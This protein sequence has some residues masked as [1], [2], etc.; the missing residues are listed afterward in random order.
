[1]FIPT[2]NL[3]SQTTSEK[4]AKFRKLM[5]EN[6]ITKEGYYYIKDGNIIIEIVDQSRSNLKQ[7]ISNGTEVFWYLKLTE[8]F[9]MST[10]GYVLYVDGLP[11]GSCPS[12]NI[13]HYLFKLMIFN[14]YYKSTL[15]NNI[16]SAWATFSDASWRH[17]EM[18]EILIDMISTEDEN[19]NRIFDEVKV[20]FN[21]LNANENNDIDFEDGVIILTTFALGGDRK[22]LIIG[23]GGTTTRMISI[24]NFIF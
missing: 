12:K 14:E 6:K 24:Q 13:T 19:G 8:I 16:E 23:L 7:L 22:T 18:L 3:N 11:V 15:C 9:F 21:P 20:K 4:I 10:A 2:T 17:R 5:V 1:M